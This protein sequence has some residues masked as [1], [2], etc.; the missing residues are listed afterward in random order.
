MEVALFY[1]TLFFAFLVLTVTEI[2]NEQ[3]AK[4]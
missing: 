3:K 4:N 1:T 2:V